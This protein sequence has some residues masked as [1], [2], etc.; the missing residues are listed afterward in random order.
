VFSDTLKSVRLVRSSDAVAEV[1]GLKQET[2][3]HLDL[4]GASLAA[5]L[6]DLIDEFRLFVMPVVVGGGKPFFGW[7]RNSTSGSRS[8]PDPMGVAGS[9]AKFVA[10]PPART[11]A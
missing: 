3:G 9:Q 10:E 1:T 11:P 5:S 2:D 8:C 4:G 6:V 7:E